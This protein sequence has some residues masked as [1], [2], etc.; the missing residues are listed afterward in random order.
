MDVQSFYPTLT[1]QIC[2]SYW[3]SAGANLRPNCDFTGGD[4][5]DEKLGVKSS[6][7]FKTKD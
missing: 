2:C 4:Q 6:R 1:S 5:I 7:V 3:K